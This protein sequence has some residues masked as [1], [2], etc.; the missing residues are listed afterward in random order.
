MLLLCRIWEAAYEQLQME[1]GVCN[2]VQKYS[3]QLVQERA[4]ASR[5]S[6]LDIVVSRRPSSTVASL[7]PWLSGSCPSNVVVLL[8]LK[9]EA[10]LDKGIWL[11]SCLG[12]S[13][14]S[15]LGCTTAAAIACLRSRLHVAGTWS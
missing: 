14:Q 9:F 8:C 2:L 15:E 10:Q 1:K 13:G 6:I 3:P 5:S 7:A 12:V 11:G 4:L